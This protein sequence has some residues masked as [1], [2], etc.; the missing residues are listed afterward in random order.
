MKNF[1]DFKVGQKYTCVNGDDI[2]LCIGFNSK[3]EPI[4][5]QLTRDNYFG[6]FEPSLWSEYKEPKSGKIYNV[7]FECQNG[8]ISSCTFLE[9]G[10]A[11]AWKPISMK[12]LAIKEVSWI[13]GEGL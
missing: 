7:I 12:I 10:P 11:R 8:T 1:S 13:E 3:K 4:V 5:E 2:F 9:K 6:V